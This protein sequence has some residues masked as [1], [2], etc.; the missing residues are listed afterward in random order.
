[1]AG[2]AERIDT[3]VVGGGAREKIIMAWHRR[4]HGGKQQAFAG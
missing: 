3:G 1:L 4:Q 2:L